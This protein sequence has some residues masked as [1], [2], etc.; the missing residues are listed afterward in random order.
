MFQFKIFALPA[1][2]LALT[3]CGLVILLIAASSTVFPQA[4]LDPNFIPS[5]NSDVRIIVV[6]PDGKILIGGQFTVMNGVERNYISRLNV[7]GTLDT[8]FE[9]NPSWSVE[10][11]AI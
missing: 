2:K 11:I 4:I 3:F 6:Q 7:D 5:V 8:S 1:S 9:A 10:A